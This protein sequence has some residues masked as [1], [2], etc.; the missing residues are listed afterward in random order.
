M[1]PG[2][3]CNA[4]KGRPADGVADGTY[5]GLFKVS[6]ESGE[7]VQY[8]KGSIVTFKGKTY[9]ADINTD[10]SNGTPLH[11]NSGWIQIDPDEIDGGAF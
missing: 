6:D 9:L 8:K 1:S 4:Y 2:F 11:K 3:V 7:P 10:S 5:E